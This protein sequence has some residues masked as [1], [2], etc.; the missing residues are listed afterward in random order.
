MEELKTSVEI[1]NI[2]G[3]QP[4]PAIKSNSI[5]Y[6]DEDSDTYGT[7]TYP[8]HIKRNF[9]YRHVWNEVWAN[10]SN[11]TFIMIGK[12]GSGKSVSVIKMAQDLDP[13]FTLERICY[14]LEDFLKLIDVGDS[15]G[16]LHPGN[17]IIF[18]EI[19]T[20]Q[21]AESRS[22]MTKSNKIM[23]YVTASFRAKRLVVFY[24]LPSLTQLDKNIRDINVTGVFEVITK[25]IKR[26]KNLCKFQWSSYDAKSQNVYRIFPRLVSKTGMIF[27]VDSVWI[28]IP[29]KATI[30]EYKKKKMEYL[31][32]NI[33]RWREMANKQNKKDV[34]EKI[35]DKEILSKIQ[36][37]KEDFIVGGRFNAYKIKEEFGIGAIRA[38]HLSG[39]LNKSHVF[40]E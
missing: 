29:D 6:E 34:A 14:N 33:A 13:T 21:G 12:P 26:R 8:E 15:N 35:T 38:N 5:L 20:D 11:A 2:V 40:D 1:P 25:D 19:V 3:I 4:R 32:K 10:D 28:G 30:K 36:M 37:L 9:I 31:A 23:N 7:R 16:P 24:C 18:D 17:V 39:Y 22:A 27:K